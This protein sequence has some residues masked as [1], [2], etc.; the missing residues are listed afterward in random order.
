LSRHRE[1]TFANANIVALRT[2][3][4]TKTSFLAKATSYTQLLYLLFQ[5][6]AGFPSRISDSVSMNMYSLDD[7]APFADVAWTP[8]SAYGKNSICGGHFTFY[9]TSKKYR[10]NTTGIKVFCGPSADLFMLYLASIRPVATV[11]SGQLS[12]S[13]AL[14][15]NFPED[16]LSRRWNASDVRRWLRKMLSAKFDAAMGWM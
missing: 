7:D 5:L 2:D 16:G 14:W 13:N 8:T 6:V 12:Q 15:V 4:G 1:T 11:L 10:C 9:V 3:N